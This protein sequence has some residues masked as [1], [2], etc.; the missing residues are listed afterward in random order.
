MEKVALIDYEKESYLQQ[1][2]W[3]RHLTLFDLSWECVVM[4]Y[5]FAA[6][7]MSTNDHK[8]A[9]KYQLGVTNKF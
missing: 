2:S 7:H 6:V 3:N 8:S 4:T 1:E 5:F 9:K